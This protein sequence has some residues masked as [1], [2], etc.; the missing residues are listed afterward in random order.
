M[1]IT[2]EE[3]KDLTRTAINA[4]AEETAEKAKP[5]LDKIENEI[6]EAATCARQTCCIGL[7]D[8]INN[9]DFPDL[10]MAKNYIAVKVRENGFTAK[11]DDSCDPILT[12]KW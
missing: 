10:D 2:V 9:S 6:L 8:F 1:K 12:V 7:R 5:I 3:A 11:W 4:R